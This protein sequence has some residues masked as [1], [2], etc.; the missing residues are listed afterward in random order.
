MPLDLHYHAQIGLQTSTIFC[1]KIELFFI[2][3][4]S[5]NCALIIYWFKAGLAVVISNLRLLFQVEINWLFQIKVIWLFQVKVTWLF[6]SYGYLVISKL[7]LSGLSGMCVC[8]YV[9]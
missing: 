5:L 2:T 3:P 6:H 4:S 8:V 9:Q 7:R 1:K